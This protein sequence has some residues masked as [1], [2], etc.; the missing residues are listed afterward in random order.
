MDATARR[1]RT[2]SPRT[3][4]K[5]L[6]A[7]TLGCPRPS[8]P[9]PDRRLAPSPPPLPRAAAAP[10]QP[11]PL[12]RRGSLRPAL[13]RRDGVAALAGHALAVALLATGGA[14]LAWLL[15]GVGEAGEQGTS[16]RLR[17]GAFIRL[18]PQGGGMRELA[19]YSLPGRAGASDDPRCEPA[20]LIF[21]LA[22]RHE[23]PA[24]EFRSPVPIAAPVGPS[25]NS[26]PRR[27]GRA[28]AQVWPRFARRP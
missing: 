28:E 5:A 23:R 22:A 10:R 15:P 21:L 25:D 12:A 9:Q 2:S 1:S 24:R 27:S 8:G 16:A 13:L 6:Q 18:Q 7:A 19:A 20:G 26:L 14:M 4:I 11:V 3:S 17:R